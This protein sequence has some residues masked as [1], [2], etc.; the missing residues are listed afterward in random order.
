MVS[1]GTICWANIGRL[2]YSVSEKALM[3]VTGGKPENLTL[4]CP[5][6][7]YPLNEEGWR[8]RLSKKV[9][10]L[11]EIFLLITITCSTYWS[12]DSYPASAKD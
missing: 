10:G 2:V 8:R 5:A 4:I 3:E 6:E 9:G 1:P 7:R 11:G 12:A